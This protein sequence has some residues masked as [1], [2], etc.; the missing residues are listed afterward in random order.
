M[1]NIGIMKGIEIVLEVNKLIFLDFLD[2]KGEVMH[3]F[4]VKSHWFM[5][6]S[7]ENKCLWLEGIPDMGRKFLLI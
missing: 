3:D 4:Y 7:P 5:D 2:K 1:V 6:K